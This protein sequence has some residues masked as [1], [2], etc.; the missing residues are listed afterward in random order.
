MKQR[1]ICFSDNIF[2][3]T[4]SGLVVCSKCLS[5]CEYKK[6]RLLW[7]VFSVWFE[8]T[9]LKKWTSY[10]IL[11]AFVCIFFLVCG[12]Q[13]KYMHYITGSS[14]AK[15]RCHASILQLHSP[16]WAFDPMAWLLW[17]SNKN[18][19]TA[20]ITTHP[21]SLIGHQ[22]G[23]QAWCRT[24]PLD[25]RSFKCLLQQHLF[26]MYATTLHIDFCANNNKWSFSRRRNFSP[27]FLP[28]SSSHPPHPFYGPQQK[29]EN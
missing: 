23:L 21:A 14:P 5:N 22:E 17:L 7:K 8:L 27:R 12:V 2:F 1:A 10:H 19:C 29:H 3:S 26:A 6:W 18:V 11:H 4:S 13:I 25:R 9:T 24:P 15:A 16:R 20:W 28:P